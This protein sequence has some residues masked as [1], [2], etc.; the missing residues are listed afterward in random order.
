MQKLSDS[1]GTEEGFRV[2]LVEDDADSGQALCL[3]LQ[4]RGYD[5]TFVRDAE[6]VVTGNLLAAHDVLVCDI[7]LRGM[8]GVDLLRH[9]RKTDQDYP[10]ILM[11]G[12]DGLESAIQ[13]IR[14]GAQD[15]ILKPLENMDDLVR[16]VKNAAHSYRLLLA[17]R[18]LRDG[19]RGTC[20]RLRA[21]SQRLAEIQE[22]EQ[23]RISRELHD[24]MGQGLT[25]LGIQISI[26]IK[27]IDMGDAK[28]ASARLSDCSHQVSELAEATR[29]IVTELRPAVLDDYGL[30]AA[31]RWCAKQFASRTGLGL[32]LDIQD[33]QPRL[34][35][36]QETAL[37][38]IAQEA[39]NNIAKHAAAR[40]VCISLGDASRAVLLCIRDDGD[41]FLQAV[42]DD[43]KSR[44]WGL[45][46]MRER[47][48]A[49]DAS[50]TCCSSPGQ[51][52]EIAVTVRRE[53]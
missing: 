47:A 30:S 12:Y 14:L 16:P 51:G 23:R 2:L 15:Y 21:L 26:A 39:L 25:T 34:T 10:V 18:K 22:A 27:L 24:R 48:E 49:V 11:T 31:L 17:N 53:V 50:F 44:G 43:S 7:R 32:T 29:H 52:T 5:V 20:E 36:E 4:R 42:P 28:A 33:I 40:T 13:A 1:V 8:S 45:T 37:F 6:D 3:M 38:R 35:P 9:V 19:L 46:M 41:G